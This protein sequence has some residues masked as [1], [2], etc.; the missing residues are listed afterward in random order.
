[1][2]GCRD[3]SMTSDVFTGRSSVTIWLNITRS[4]EL[5]KMKCIHGWLVHNKNYFIH[6]LPALFNP[7]EAGMCATLWINDIQFLYRSCAFCRILESQIV[8]GSGT[9]GEINTFGKVNCVCF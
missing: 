6:L 8:Y 2:T 7:Q 1:M 4:K 9:E 5:I 3:A